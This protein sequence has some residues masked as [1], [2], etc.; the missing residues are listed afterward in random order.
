MMTEAW[1]AVSVDGGNA[2]QNFKVSDEPFMPIPI[3]GTW[4]PGYQ[5]DYIGIA[6]LNNIAY[7]VWADGRTGH[8]QAWMSKVTFGP[9]VSVESSGDS[10]IPDQYTIEQNYPNPFNP[11]TVITFSLPKSEM[12]KIEVYSLLGQKIETLLDRSMSAGTHKVE[13]MAKDLPSGVY[14]YRI[15]AGGFEQVKKML[16]IK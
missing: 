12:V 7:P 5:G 2:W 10:N 15:S 11:S 14:L 8:Y 13:F 4:S 16:L 3:T 6:A 1:M 9:V